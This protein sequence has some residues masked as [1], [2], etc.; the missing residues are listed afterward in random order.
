MN[1]ITFQSPFR[2]YPRWVR[3]NGVI[4]GEVKYTL[5]RPIDEY[6]E[7]TGF[8]G[9]KCTSVTLKSKHEFADYTIMGKIL[10]HLEVKHGKRI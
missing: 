9:F 1:K 4:I 8:D 10:E 6:Y 7:F 5:N 2:N 3:C